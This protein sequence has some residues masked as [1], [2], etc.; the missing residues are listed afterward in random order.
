M[1]TPRESK[2]VSVTTRR[3]RLGRWR[4]HLVAQRI[5]GFLERVPRLVADGELSLQLA[6]CVKMPARHGLQLAFDDQRAGGLPHERVEH[7]MS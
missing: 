4:Q 5:Q 1:R 2:M 6:A 7:Q 3:R